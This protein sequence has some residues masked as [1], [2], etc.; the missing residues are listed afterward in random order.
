MSSLWGFLAITVIF[1]PGGE[2]D[3]VVPKGLGPSSLCTDEEDQESAGGVRRLLIA[4]GA[5]GERMRG[6][7]VD[8]G[9]G[10]DEVLSWGPWSTFWSE[11]GEADRLSGHQFGESVTGRGNVGIWWRHQGF[12][13]GGHAGVLA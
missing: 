8:R 10:E 13:P 4:D 12:D 9:N 6:E 3:D 11:N 1:I 2:S 7:L 5:D